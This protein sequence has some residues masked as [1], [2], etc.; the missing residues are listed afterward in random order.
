MCVNR[1][2]PPKLTELKMC[3]AGRNG[4]Q[5]TCSCARILKRIYSDEL[6]TEACHTFKICLPKIALFVSENTCVS[7]SDEYLKKIRYILKER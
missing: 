7:L 6:N 1:C 3:K 4:T 2:F 5:K